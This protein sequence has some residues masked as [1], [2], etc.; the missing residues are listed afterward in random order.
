MDINTLQRHRSQIFGA[1]QFPTGGTLQTFA[2][3]AEND[4]VNV[5]GFS[6]FD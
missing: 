6:I 5:A 3:L 1:A 2:H 4:V